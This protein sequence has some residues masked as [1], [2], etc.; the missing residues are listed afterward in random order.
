MLSDI[1]M[2]A[3]NETRAAVVRPTDGGTMTV[4]TARL[5]SALP[6]IGRGTS[7]HARYTP[8]SAAPARAAR[9]RDGLRVLTQHYLEAAYAGASAGPSLCWRGGALR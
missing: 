4:R 8:G 2:V 1:G 3:G 9:A 5:A 6:D 7:L